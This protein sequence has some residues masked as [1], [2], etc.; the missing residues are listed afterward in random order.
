M[1]TKAFKVSWIIL[2]IVHCVGVVLSLIIFIIPT[3]F[4]SS[5]FLS[6][7]GQ[8]WADFA[9][10]N[11]KVTS[12]FIL[13]TYEIGVFA[14]N[15]SIIMVILTL[16]AYRKGVKW[17]WYLFLISETIGW[18][19][20]LSVDIPTGDMTVVMMTAILLVLAYGGLFIGAKAILKKASS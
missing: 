13:Q 7:T 5:E 1:E 8:Q 20:L 2:L 16:V 19:G 10:S 17:T 11:A 9:A 6:S 12:F 18:G 3:F 4:L 14:I 15:L